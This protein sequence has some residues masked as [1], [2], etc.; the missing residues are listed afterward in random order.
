MSASAQF[1]NPSAAA[2]RLGVSAKAL[3]LYEQHGLIAPSRTA[4]GWRA[5]G[6][7]EMARAAE[8]VT[9]RMLGLSLSQV[10][11][12]FGDDPQDLEPTLAA[13]QRHSKAGSANWPEQ[14][15]KSV[16]SGPV[17]RGTSLRPREN[18]CACWDRPPSSASP[19][20]F[21]GPGAANGSN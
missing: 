17:S 19:S 12:V 10:A 21:P 15:R 8:I 7:D 4:A 2:R 13:H 3:R 9:L 14:S 1:L 6:P 18:W 16:K 11:R 20:I 5:Y